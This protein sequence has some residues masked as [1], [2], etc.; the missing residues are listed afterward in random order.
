M[1][2]PLKFHEMLKRLKAH[3]PGFQVYENRGK[4][5]HCMLYHPTIAGRA[6][7]VPVPRHG[8]RDVSPGVL[9]QIA[10]AFNLPPNFWG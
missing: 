8:G 5:S 7:S 1:P 4:G 9:R 10:R 2:R 3:N 6:A